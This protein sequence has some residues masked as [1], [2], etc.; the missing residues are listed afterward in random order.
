M[1]PEV[2]CLGSCGGRDTEAVGDLGLVEALVIH[3]IS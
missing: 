3:Q 1:H 2:G